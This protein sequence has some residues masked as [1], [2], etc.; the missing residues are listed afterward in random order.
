[1]AAGWAGGQI[2]PERLLTH[3]QALFYTACKL[4]GDRT[5]AEDLVQETYLKASRALAQLQHPDQCKAW[6]FRIMFNTWNNQRRRALREPL[7]IEPTRLSVTYE[8]AAAHHPW[9]L[10][11]S[12]EETLLKKEMLLELDAALQDLPEALRVVI[13]LVD[14]H[15]LTYEESARALEL[16]RGTVMSRLYRARR[17]LEQRFGGGARKAGEDAHGWL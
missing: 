3:L 9:F 17:L 6:L 12:P 15:G 10:P 4:T 2:D 7:L 13:F 11:L 5:A 14:V 1:M 16:P 8:R